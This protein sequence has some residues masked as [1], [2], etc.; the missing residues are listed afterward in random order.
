MICFLTAAAPDRPTPSRRT[1]ALLVTPIVAL[2]IASNIGDVLTTTWAQ[3]H[4]LAL[5]AL[6]ARSRI[7]VLTTN[8]L[9]TVPYYVVGTLRLLISDPLFYL[10]GMFYGDNALQWME[11]KAPT[12]GDLLRRAERYFGKA[13]YP[14]VFVAPNNFICLFAGAA[15][16]PIA[17]FLVLNVTGTVVRL[18]LIR[19]VGA[20]FDEPIQ[21]VLDFFAR[22][23]LQLFVLSIVIV[24]LSVWSERRKGKGEIGA[25][26]DL[27]EELAH[28]GAGPLDEVDPA[29]TDGA[30]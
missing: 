5:V 29:E 9:D 10:L 28:P 30:S 20:T 22:Y 13:A 26:R 4:P 19:V 1:L 18:Y 3:D 24:G 16:M 15:G 23:R 25:I 11:R 2:V 6:N 17:A 12:Y 14:L 8:Q 21:A 27:E 7:L